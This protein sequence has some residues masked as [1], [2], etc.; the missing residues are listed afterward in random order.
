[1]SQIPAQVPT[2]LG[3]QTFPIDE[4]YGRGARIFRSTSVAAPV[5]L[6]TSALT[7][8][9]QPVVRDRPISIQGVV[10]GGGVL[11]HLSL[12]ERSGPNAPWTLIAQDTDFN[13]P[14]VPNATILQATNLAS[15]TASGS[16]FLIKMSGKAAY[17]YQLSAQ[18]S[19]S[20]TALQLF[21]GI[22]A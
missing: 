7:M 22:G 14:T 6:S 15:T 1:M 3:T 8:V 21:Y 13:S 17:Q 20:T 18:G 19:T 12:Y 9:N 16:N 11:S 5:V 10:S 2:Q 4:D